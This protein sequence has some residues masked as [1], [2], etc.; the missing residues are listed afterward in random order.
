MM[1]PITGMHLTI[2]RRSVYLST[3][4][5]FIS[6]SFAPHLGQYEG[7]SERI[8]SKLCIADFAGWTFCPHLSHR[9]F[10]R[11]GHQILERILFRCNV[12]IV[13]EHFKMLM[14]FIN[15]IQYFNVSIK[16]YKNGTKI[17]KIEI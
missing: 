2:E 11:F 12:T 5:C 1:N 15:G 7:I 8:T 3:C 13:E 16:K 9:G 6:E 4:F 17:Q 10:F 14:N